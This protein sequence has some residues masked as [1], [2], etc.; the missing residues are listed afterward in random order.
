MIQTKLVT[1]TMPDEFNRDLN[2]ELSQLKKV[3]S[4]EFSTA[5]T[6]MPR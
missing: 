1:S 2:Q 4:I 3:K 6:N 5:V